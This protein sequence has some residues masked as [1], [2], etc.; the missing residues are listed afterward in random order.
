MLI[1][2]IFRDATCIIVSEEN[3]EISY[4]REGRLYQNIRKD[5]LQKLIARSLFH[6]IN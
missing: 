5:E 4:A 3:G 2:S 1:C 6:S